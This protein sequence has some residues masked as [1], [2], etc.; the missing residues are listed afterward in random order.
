VAQY[1]DYG[2]VI[3]TSIKS[4]IKN[5]SMSQSN[6]YP[7]E[8]AFYTI[9]LYPDSRLP[10]TT[11][12]KIKTPREIEI[13]RAE[14]EDCYIDSSRKV[15]NVCYYSGTNTLEIQKGLRHISGQ[16]YYGQITIVFKAFNPPSNFYEGIELV[17]EISLDETWNFPIASIEG[18]LSA[19]FECNYPC[20]SCSPF[21]ANNCESC[22]EGNREK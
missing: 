20:M 6:L 3:E 19:S 2:L 12:F 16:D 21:D 17:L 15:K 7:G 8:E 11:A 14:S 22:P 9:Q 13:V 18:G 5:L 10:S 1:S 4:S